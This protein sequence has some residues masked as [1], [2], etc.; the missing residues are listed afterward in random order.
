MREIERQAS[1][2]KHDYVFC[3]TE[4]VE[5]A[6]GGRSAPVSRVLW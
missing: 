2:F 3:V 6:H 4:V 1:G 5:A